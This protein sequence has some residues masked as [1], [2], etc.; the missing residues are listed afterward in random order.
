MHDSERRC[1]AC[2]RSL[3]KQQMLR[4]IVD[5][6]GQIWPD[7]LQKLPGRGVYLCMEEGCLGGM[8]DKRLQPLR[9]KFTVNFPQ[10]QLLRERT[11]D[12]LEKLLAQSFTRLRAKTE[13]GRDAVMH[14]LWNNAPLMLLIAADAGS[15]V[16]RQV[17]TAVMKRE[18]AGHVVVIVRVESRQWLGEMLGRDDVAVAAVDAKGSMA[19]NV[20]KLQ[21]YCNW[22]GQLKVIG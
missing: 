10:W 17:E 5:G 12:I 2:R 14:R 16:V 9:A 18:E 13:I 19:G 15:A 7:L 1:I 22:Y 4:L 3:A 11:L 8:N 20:A 21:R 6:D